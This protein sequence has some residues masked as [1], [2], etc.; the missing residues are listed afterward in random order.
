MSLRMLMSEELLALGLEF[1]EKGPVEPSLI[2]GVPKT[3][4]GK[5][6]STKVMIQVINDLPTGHNRKPS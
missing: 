1:V 2:V 5:L 3:T 6:L 4:T